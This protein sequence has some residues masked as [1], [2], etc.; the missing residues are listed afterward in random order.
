LVGRGE[1][2]AGRLPP[3]ARDL[4]SKLAAALERVGQA[5]RTELRQQAREL[6]L[7]PTQAQVL[8]RLAH[9]P[10]E[11]PRVG[12][13]ADELDVSAPTLSDAVAVLLR[14]GLVE[15]RADPA[16]ARARA[17]RLTR[18]GETAARRLSDWDERIRRPL[19]E[20]SRTDKETA[21]VLLLDL[22]ARLYQDGVVSVAR[23]CITCRHLRSG[24]RA[25]GDARH[26]CALLDMPLEDGDLRVDCPEQEPA[27]A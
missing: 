12:A 26:H 8:L 7:T 14:K 9:Q 27:V 15:R 4:D 16:D 22:I 18:G 10:R 13:L 23:T 20:V 24:T 5:L 25:D 2:P 21:L 17:L 3:G 19:A 11:H 6:D 1:E